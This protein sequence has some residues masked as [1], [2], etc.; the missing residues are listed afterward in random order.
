MKSMLLIL[1]RY[2]RENCLLEESIQIDKLVMDA[3]GVARTVSKSDEGVSRTVWLTDMNFAGTK[4]HLK[5]VPIF[6]AM[7]SY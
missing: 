1:L 3:V 6:L 5:Q 4:T 2:G 7:Y